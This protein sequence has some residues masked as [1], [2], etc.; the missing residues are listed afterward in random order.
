V[1]LIAAWAALVVGAVAAVTALLRGGLLLLYVAIGAS[2][3][4]M[5]L[6]VGHLLKGGSGTAG[7]TGAPG[8]PGTPGTEERR[9]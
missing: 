4:A 8:T 2:A 6:S 5:T 3:I 1:L 9:S 7:T